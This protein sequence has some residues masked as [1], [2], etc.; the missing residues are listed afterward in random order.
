M[1]GIVIFTEVN[2]M[3]ISR[4]FGSSNKIPE[5][6]V[7]TYE[8]SGDIWNLGL[9]RRQILPDENNTEPLYI[10]GYK[11][12]VE[13]G[14]VLD[15][16]EAR[17]IWMDTGEK[18]IL[19]IGIDCVALDSSTVQKIRESLSDLPDC[20]YIHVYATHTHAGIDTLGMWGPVGIEGK[21]EDYM[22]K[23]IQAAK[24]SGMEACEQ[25]TEGK[26]YFGQIKTE[27]MLYDSRIPRV[28]DENL[29]QLRFEPENEDSGIR[30]YFYGAHA[31]SL[32]GNNIRLSRDFPGMLCDQVAEVTGDNTMFCPGAIGGLI[33]T[34]EF[35]DTSWYS[36]ENMEMTADKLT[37]YA[38]SITKESEQEL[39]PVILH[40][41][42][43]CAVPMD[44]IAFWLYKFLGILG[45]KA[46]PADSATG[47]GVETEM[48]V[49]MMDDLA[50]TFIPGEIFPELVLGTEYGDASSEN[51]TPKSLS[52]IAKEHGIENMLIAG[53]AN[54]EIGY[55]VPPSDFLLNE[56]LPYLERTMDYK[57]E[58]HYEET[59]SIGPEC[60]NV[61][62]ETFE[63]LV[64]ELD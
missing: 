48:S 64:N 55:I 11:N 41:N 38:L 39:K 30:L 36:L 60:A 31:E 44:N 15:Y 49:F 5:Y 58:D 59:N 40:D 16:C 3:Q 62:A 12:G 56:E 29:Y 18:G 52:Q 17:A 51:E 23:L 7:K 37:E 27:N 2:D 24:E 6:Q 14:N 26:M 10:A 47:Y 54:D 1:L 43:K 42:T 57:C 21:N 32:R 19:L 8:S 63:K 35:T 22:E 61:I 33:M 53:L 50:I 20:E 46:I 25:R 4:F 34:D 45:N 28:Y 9:G 13:I